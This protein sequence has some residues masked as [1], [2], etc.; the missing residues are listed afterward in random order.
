MDVIQPYIGMDQKEPKLSRLGGAEWQRAKT[1]ARQ[2]VQKLAMDLVEL[3]AAREAAKGYQFS[4]DTPWQQQ[5]E[6]MFP[7][8]ETPDQERAIKEIKRDME[9]EKV[10]DRLLCGDVGYGKTEVAI[11]AAF[12]AVMD[13]KQVALLAP[14]T[15]LAQQ[16]FNTFVERFATSCQIQVISRFRTAA[17]QRDILKALKEGN[18]DIIIGTHRLLGK[19]VVFKD[20]GLLIVDEE[21]RFGVGH[22][23]TIKI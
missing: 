6:E 23:E 9:S 11:R 7:Y 4:P 15:I 10:M 20:L 3:Y 19:D 21:Q 13:G 22:K 18:I 16:H 2:S 5:F 14:T 12:K 8:E 17:Q 1:K